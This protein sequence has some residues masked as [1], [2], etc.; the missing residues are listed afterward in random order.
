M[1]QKKSNKKTS[2]P[3]FYVEEMRVW[4]RHNDERL[5]DCDDHFDQYCREI[6]F[7]ENLIKSLKVLKGLELEQKGLIR[8]RVCAAKR[9]LDMYLNQNKKNPCKSVKSA[10]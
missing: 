2:K 1:S 7:H 6:R 3:D 9:D 10:I 4:L 8:H 5:S